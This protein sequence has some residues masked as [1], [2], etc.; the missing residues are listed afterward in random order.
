MIDSAYPPLRQLEMLRVASPRALISFES[1]ESEEGTVPAEVLSWLREAGCPCLE[2]PAGGAAAVA[3]LAA[4]AG[5]APQVRV[6]P[7]DVACIGFTSGSTGGPKGILGL[8]GSLS[9]FL[10]FYC[11]QFGLGPDDRFSLLASLGHDPLQREIFTCLYLGGTI[12]V[13]DP[14]DYGI[15]GRLASWL[16]REQ[17]TVVHLTPTLGQLVTELPPDGTREL[18]PSLRRALLVGESLTRKDVARLRTLAPGVSCI[19]LYGA[20]ETQRALSFHLVTPEEALEVLP[21]GRGMPDAQLLVLSPGGGLAGLGELGEIVMRSPHLARGYLDHAELTAERFQVNPFTGEPSDRI[22]RTGDLGRYRADGEVVFAGRLDQQVKLRG[23]RIELGEIEG[24]LASLPG[25]LEAAVLL[26]TDLPGGAGLAAYVRTAEGRETALRGELEARLPGYMVPAS[27][28]RLDTLPRNANG[29]LDRRALLRIAPEAGAAAV[30]TLPRTPAEELL[31]GIWTQL[32]GVEPIGIDQSFFELGGHSLLA[33]QMT[34]RVKDVF[35]VELPLRR[36]FAAPTVAELA[37]ETERASGES[38][39][40]PLER[41][42]RGGDLPLSFA[43]QR[44]WFLDQL[45]AG[46]PVYHMPIALGLAGSLAVAALR[47][48]LREVVRR[49]ES[50]RT[51]FAAVDGEPVQR[52]QAPAEMPEIL[53]PVIDL[54]G[55]PAGRAESELTHWVREHA[56]RP[57]DLAAGPLMRSVLVRLGA[58]EHAMLLNQHHIVSDGWSRGVLVREVVTLY[59]AFA[60][61]LPSPLPELAVQYPDYA[62]WQRNWLAGEVLERQVGYWRRRLEGLPELLELPADRPRPVFRSGRGARYAFQIPLAPLRG[63]KDLGRRLG[64]TD[65]M[66]L[67]SLFQAL[68]SRLSGQRDLA[69]GTVIA[70]RGRLELEPL[71]GFFANTLVFRADLNGRPGLRDL[72]LRSR[73]T[74]LEAYAHQDLPFESLVEALQPARAMSH[75]PLFQV[76]LVL[77]NTPQEQISLPGLEAT[78]IEGSG[79]AGG[80]RFDLT[81]DLAETPLGLAGS[82]EYATDLFDRPTVARLA[83]HFAALLSAA[84]A[85]PAHPISELPL[86]GAAERQQLV[87]EE[88]DTEAVRGPEETRLC[89]TAARIHELFEWQAARQPQEA[90]AVVG[91]GMALTYAELDARANRLA[92]S[93]WRLGVGPESRVGLCVERSPEMVVALLGIL[94]AGGAYV[95]L[96]PAHPAERLAL[97]LGDS[98]PS[99]LVTEERWLERLALAGKPENAAGPRVLCL[100]RD[101]ER[102]AAEAGSAL[103]PLPGVGS[104]RR[105][106]PESLAYIIYTS[107]STGRPKGVSLPHRAVVSFLY[108]MAERLGLG[109]HEVVPAL[110]TL[111]FDIAGLEIYLPLALGGRVEVVDR[112]EAADGHRL[113]ARVAAS[114]VTVLQATPATWRLLL[115]SGWTGQAGLKALCGGE[116][117]PWALA[118][119]LRARGVELWNVYG[120]TETAIW[121]SALAVAAAAATAENGAAVGLGRP[122]ANTRFYVADAESGLVP[123]GVSGELLI[124]GAGVARGYW[125]RPELAAERFVPDPWSAAAG[126]RLYRTGDLV[127]RRAGG[128]LDFLGRIDHQVKLRGFRIELGEI[129][130]VLALHPAVHAAAVLLRDDLPGGRGLAAY[131]V[132]DGAG[133]VRELRGWLEDRLPGYMVPAAF[134]L[135]ETLPL[136]PNGKVDRRALARRAWEIPLAQGESQGEPRAPRN[137]IEEIVASVYAEVLQLARVGPDDNFFQLGGHSLLGTR[138]ISR[139]HQVLEVE[140]P[141]RALFEAPTVAGLA[142]E[143]E[144]LR[145]GGPEQPAIVSFHHDLPLV[146][147]DRAADLPLSFAQQRMWFIDQ[148]EGGSLYNIPIALRLHG[149]LSVAVLSRALGEV[150][151]RHEV[152]RTVFPSAGGRARQVILPPP[153]LNT[154]AVPLVDLTGLSPALRQ[155]EAEGLVTEE[156]RRPFD[157]ARGPLWRVGLWRLDETEHVLLLAMHHIVSDAWSLGV[158]VRE[159]TALYPAENTAGRPSPLPELPVQYADFAAWQRSWLS[160]DVLE[161]E[162]RYWRDRL[163][164]APPVLELPT[165]RPH[166][167]VQ[168]FRGAVRPLSLPPALS[169]ALAALSRREGATLF[170]TLVSAL[171]VLLSRF[172]GQAD[173][174][175]GTVVAGRHRLEIEGLIGFFVNTLVLRPG[176]SA[177]PCFTE[178]LSRVRREALD[179]YAHQDLPFEKLVEDL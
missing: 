177:E 109:A 102:I 23:F 49:H 141:L 70:N 162:L 96:D 37:A 11:R 72:L 126:A 111:T 82:L 114:G 115:D 34:S 128:E 150:V 113:A 41:V 38:G 84:V 152:L 65:F 31:A 104:E 132:A 106:E 69:V 63:L 66:V 140:L 125:G 121:S 165:D 27:F 2:L 98:D 9:H 64:A 94:K 161:G 26:R 12:V 21:L 173:L 159:I 119:E 155:P 17:V 18:V 169:A 127:R 110:T 50:L 52:I 171:S 8:H 24:V 136:T 93:L 151:R 99:V 43:Q 156:A 179:A 154:V 122:I 157:L 92:R 74:A 19:N 20:T 44:L 130:S 48:S 134:Q 14:A 133:E 116:A 176:L 51:V 97:V 5:E 160:G 145:R 167:A 30:R 78:L 148:L 57:F 137:A 172:S 47:A 85:A 81:L 77:Q 105:W 80:A 158:L 1:P 25:V 146:R 10:P 131:I 22:Y 91:Q 138:L 117:L 16:C 54:G 86:L 129:E 3:E 62:V 61:G 164:G 42:E 100:D 118:A 175:L 6:G 68:L 135:L 28:V 29:K 90:L 163:A 87:C 174:T 55:L 83:A 166:P 7:E 75:T 144:R 13:P 46:S 73:E 79:Q 103:D 67:L 101:R 168:S 89:G 39:A 45:Q 153:L 53:L 142:A 4:F 58:D 40:P 149:P 108:A 76:M 15:T 95:P 56:E 124:G 59:G 123:A 33:T 143:I 147:V 32:L 88:N 178:L 170:M 120:P 112:E 60:A 107:G 35:G 71:I 139:L 36:L